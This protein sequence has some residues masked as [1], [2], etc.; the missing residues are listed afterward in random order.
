MRRFSVQNDAEMAHEATQSGAVSRASCIRSSS[1]SA[2][3]NRPSLGC[4]SVEGGSTL[5]DELS[6]L[7]QCPLGLRTLL[8]NLVQLC[9]RGPAFPVQLLL[10]PL[11]WPS[12]I[13]S[14]TVGGR[15]ARPRYGMRACARPRMIV[16][17][18]V[19]SCQRMHGLLSLGSVRLSPKKD[20]PVAVGPLPV[21][22]DTP[23]IGPSS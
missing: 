22:R 21:V 10:G 19:H 18:L 3:C 6:C 12:A 20:D 16:A 1:P 17:G 5:F 8:R 7:V 23:A 2:P 9:L 13:S 14:A 11:T 15:V 4:Q